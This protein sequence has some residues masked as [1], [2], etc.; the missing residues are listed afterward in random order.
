MTHT[1]EK[2][3]YLN[4][5]WCITHMTGP[6]RTVQNSAQ[7]TTG[8]QT[9]VSGDNEIAASLCSLVLLLILNKMINA[10]SVHGL[11]FRFSTPCNTKRQ[12]IAMICPVNVGLSEC[13]HAVTSINT[14][15]RSYFK[16]FEVVVNALNSTSTKYLYN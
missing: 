13:T 5:V 6:D 11:H 12:A 4:S 3:H 16:Q 1:V 10:L 9:Q 2:Y 8:E 14:I 7:N 15:I